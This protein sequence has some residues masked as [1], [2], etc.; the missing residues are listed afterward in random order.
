MDSHQ[1][2]R[3]VP[4][5]LAIPGAGVGSVTSY[6]HRT[7]VTAVWL[8]K[9]ARGA[10]DV[11]GGAPATRETPVLD[12]ANTIAGPDAVVLTG[13]SAFGLRT[14]D[15]VMEAM[16]ERGRG[17]EVAGVRVPI[18]V[19]AAIFDLGVGD[20]AAPTVDDGK[21]AIIKA[22]VGRQ[23]VEEGRHGAGTG[24]TVGK[25]LGPRAC[26]P[27]GQGAVTLA[28][29][30]GLLVA[31]LVVV[32]AMGSVLENN[33]EVLAGPLADG[34]PQRTTDLWATSSLE[35]ISGGST[36]IGV[37]LT[38]ASFSKAELSRLARMAHDGLAR[39][40]DPVHTPWDGDTLFAVSL[41]AYHADLG[42]VGTIAA[43]AVSMAVRRGVRAAL[44]IPNED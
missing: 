25:L 22:A 41:G 35:G 4:G 13:G 15:G 21:E 9:G 6:R 23:Q 3:L 24:A 32:N 27:G 36:S 17:V 30:D 12:A 11:G 5:A 29:P 37:V 7:G 18:V 2:L 44:G 1:G 28:A 19:A 34:K 20:P 31:V 8:P 14:A 38:N 26:M 10:S 40:V 39:A 42:R 43:Q 33:G 16:Q